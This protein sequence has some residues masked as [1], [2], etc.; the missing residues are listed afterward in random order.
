MAEENEQPKETLKQST[1][2]ISNF[3]HITCRSEEISKS[4]TKDM[5]KLKIKTYPQ[6][7]VDAETVAALDWNFAEE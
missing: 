3:L 4:E 1:I 5:K 7:L 2:R 6:P